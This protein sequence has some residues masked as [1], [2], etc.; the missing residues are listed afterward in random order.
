MNRYHKTNLHYR[1]TLEELS[2]IS[3]VSV[4]ETRKRKILQDALLLETLQEIEAEADEHFSL[5]NG[6][7]LPE[8]D[9]YR[10]LREF[11][12]SFRLFE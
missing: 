10:K 8:I 6:Y 4:S 7:T 2:A 5:T 11:L 1:Q 3:G 9:F 12:K